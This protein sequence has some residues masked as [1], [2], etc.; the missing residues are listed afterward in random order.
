MIEPEVKP[1]VKLTGRDGNA[2]TILGSVKHALRC[3]G[4]DKEYIDKYLNEATSGD[5]NHLLAVSM[6]YVDVE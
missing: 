5:Y 4:A 3:A 1:V 6:K 2:F